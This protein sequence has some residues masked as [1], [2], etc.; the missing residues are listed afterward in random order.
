MTDVCAFHCMDAGLG[1]GPSQE[2]GGRDRVLTGLY[3]I[4]DGDG[5]GWVR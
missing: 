1:V 2:S 4:L 5:G 3:F